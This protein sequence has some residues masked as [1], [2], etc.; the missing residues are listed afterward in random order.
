MTRK[1]IVASSAAATMLLVLAVC[2]VLM[3]A[4]A[5]GISINATIMIL[6]VPSAGCSAH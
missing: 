6:A 5:K 2:A 1:F 3:G 4:D